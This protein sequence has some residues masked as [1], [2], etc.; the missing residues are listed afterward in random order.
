MVCRAVAALVLLPAACFGLSASS[1]GLPDTS[2]YVNDGTNSDVALQLY[3]NCKNNPGSAVA[4]LTI[5]SVPSDVQER[6]TTAGISSF[7]ILDARV[8]RALLWDSGYTLGP[9]REPLRLYIKDGASLTSLTVSIDEY[10]ATGCTTLNC[11][12]PDNSST[13][14]NNQCN[15]DQMI[16]AS[17][18]ATETFDEDPGVHK[19]MWA[20]GGDPNGAPE[21]DIAKHKWNENS[22]SYEVYA[23]H[24]MADDVEPEYFVCQD[25]KAGIYG[26][27]VVPCVGTDKL[28]GDP[29][30]VGY[31]IPTPSDWV[32][33]WLLEFSDLDA[34]TSGSFNLLFLIPII[35][36]AIVL[37][38]AAVF[39]ARRRRRKALQ[40][41]FHHELTI[42][43]SALL[44]PV[45]PLPTTVNYPKYSEDESTRPTLSTAIPDPD[46]TIYLPSNRDRAS[47]YGDD[48]ESGS[49]SILR[50]LYNDPNL[51]GKRLPL[52]QIVLVKSLSKGAFGEVWL[53]E[54][55]GEQVAVKRLLQTKQP[56]FDEFQDFTSEIQLSASLIHPN[57]IGFVGVA[58]S[59]INNLILVLEFLPGGD[60]QNFLKRQGDLLS[61]P[62]DK[63]HIAIGLARAL[64]YLHERE[65]P[66]IHRDLKSKN[67]MLTRTL[68]PK[69]IDF[70]VSR[71]QKDDMTAGVG[72]P[73]WTAPEVLEGTRYTQQSDIYSF[74]VL[75]SE[76]DTCA[77]PYSDAIHRETGKPL[78]PFQVLK[79]VMAGNLAPTFSSRCPDRIK[80]IADACLQREPKARPT[81]RQLVD[82]LGG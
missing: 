51:V 44:S 1:S 35:V 13:Y 30:S 80:R 29:E 54:F 52:E 47:T 46:S 78:K 18:C 2:S 81:A 70:G 10:L 34:S 32:D 68:E 59:V 17:K 21:I 74:G 4:G 60:L 11:S 43:P 36:G 66:L 24:T 6:L 58:W 5:A 71:E 48:N 31:K 57:I 27:Y 77:I 64:Q 65:P 15:G 37:I 53:A 45:G 72:T 62:H 79:D 25:H 82:M 56:S 75:L 19:A 49:N 26:S 28:S 14:C 33:A 42:D 3:I 8:Q 67:V 50:A 73:Y 9:N 23:V 63:I 76:L 39:F 12:Q 69:L 40:Q 61:W 20:T 55:R 22:I 7:N 41:Q 38:L 16:N